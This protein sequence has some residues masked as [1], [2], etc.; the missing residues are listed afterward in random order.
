MEFSCYTCL[1]KI[2]MYDDV[3]SMEEIV[4]CE[5]CEYSGWI[6]CGCGD[7]VLDAKNLGYN[8]LHGKFTEHKFVG[9]CYI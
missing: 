3:Q 6:I 4:L 1:P 7:L 9:V 5:S 2:Q 8:D